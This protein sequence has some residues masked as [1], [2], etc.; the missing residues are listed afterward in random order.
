MAL[1][2]PNGAVLGISIAY[3]AAGVSYTAVTNADPAVAT[4]PTDAAIKKGDV[5]VV[6]SGWTGI[7]DR[8][9]VAGALQGTNLPLLG[10]DTGDVDEF[11]AGEGAGSLLQVT[12]WQDFSQQGDLSASG[13]EQQFWTGQFLEDK[14]GRQRQVPTNKN[15]QS[16]SLPLYFDPK[17]PWYKAA[18]RADRKRV[19]VV[20]RARLADG[21]TIYWYGYLSF[22][23]S[24]SMAANSPMQNNCTF[25]INSEE[26]FI[27]AGA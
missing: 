1:K 14:S 8:I 25:S 24:P 9:A 18:K 26:T 15:A 16:L 23:S 11:P 10:L 17:L 7:N 13:G 22:N 5:L 20:L 6:S 3:A 4:V 2:F 12:D 19:P 21:D 27:E